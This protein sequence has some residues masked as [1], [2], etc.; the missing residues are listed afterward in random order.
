MRSKDIQQKNINYY[1]EAL[2]C[3]RYDE[4]NVSQRKNVFH[5]ISYMK[6]RSQTISMMI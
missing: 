3:S 5:Q 4:A 1:K 6:R 2:N